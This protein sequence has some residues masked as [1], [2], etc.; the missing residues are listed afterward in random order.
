MDRASG[1]RIVDLRLGGRTV[2]LRVR[3]NRRAR[4]ILLRADGISDHV[5]LVLPRGAGLDEGLRFAESRQDWLLARLD[6]L[7]PRV[8]FADG[9]VFPLM[10]RPVR[11]QAVAGLRGGARLDGAALHVAGDPDFL[12]RRVT[13]W[14][15]ARAR[16]EVATRAVAMAGRIGRRPRGVTV[17]DTRSRWGSCSVDGRLSF[18]WRLVMAPEA[19]LDHV[20]A[21]EVAHLVAMNH[22]PEFHRCYREVAGGD[23]EAAE[24]WLRQ[25]GPGL[26]RYG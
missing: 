12:A 2:G 17:R 25:D 19:V 21:H 15:R 1:E 23:G 20:V 22:G 26:H 13:D 11:I 7:P 10:D 9:A 3:R 4:R 6:A 8:P 14:L 24:A 16:E 5:T 18:C